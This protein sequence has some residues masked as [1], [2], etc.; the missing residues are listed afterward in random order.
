M[1]DRFIYKL[2]KMHCNVIQCYLLSLPILDAIF[3]IVVICTKP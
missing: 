3:Q 2:L 1:Q